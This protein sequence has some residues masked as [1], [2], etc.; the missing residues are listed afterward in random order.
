MSFFFLTNKTHTVQIAFSVHVFFHVFFLFL[1]T[2]VLFCVNYVRQTCSPFFNI[3]V[4]WHEYNDVKKE[5]NNNNEGKNRYPRGTCVYCLCLSRYRNYLPCGFDK[6]FKRQSALLLLRQRP[7]K[8]TRRD[9]A[10]PVKPTRQWFTYLHSESLHDSNTKMKRLV[11][12]SCCQRAIRCAFWKKIVTRRAF[13]L[14]SSQKNLTGR[15]CV[16]TK[17]KCVPPPKYQCKYQWSWSYPE[18]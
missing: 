1:F 2:F 15:R 5:N 4:S 3:N 14:M 13:V 18:F 7:R 16:E 17:R 9:L 6:R 8:R 11:F 12:D 10:K